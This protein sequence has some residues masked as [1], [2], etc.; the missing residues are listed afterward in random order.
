MTPSVLGHPG[1][2]TDGGAEFGLPYLS[3]AVVVVLVST[4][5]LV[6]V[7]QGQAPLT[8]WL[9]E[10]LAWIVFATILV[11]ELTLGRLDM[12]RDG[13]SGL[14]ELHG[15]LAWAILSVAIALGWYLSGAT[16]G[17]LKNILPGV[18]IFHILL[19][20]IRTRRQA[21][22]VVQLYI[23][24]LA[25]NAI[26]G[27]LQYL[28]DAFYLVAP[29]DDNAWKA[30]YEGNFVLTTANGLQTTPNNLASILL[31]GIVIIGSYIY[32]RPSINW[33]GFIRVALFVILM[34]GLYVSQS[35][36]GIVWCAVGL[37]VVWIPV[38]RHLLLLSIIIPI[39]VSLSITAYGLLWSDAGGL[40][41]STTIVRVV[42][43]LTAWEIISQYNQVA[44]FG[45]GID[46]MRYW[47]N[48]VGAWNFPNAHNTWVNQIILFGWPGLA[49]YIAMWCRVL[50]ALASGCVVAR[51]EEE[52]MLRGILGALVG[53]AGMYVFEPREDGVSHVAQLFILFGLAIA[54]TRAMGY[55]RSAPRL[56]MAR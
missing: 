49:L 48:A 41:T 2:R 3:L 13:W 40:D 45:N 33:K 12:L 44:F 8:I 10:I 56:G 36:G 19:R 38:R 32:Y 15:Y 24:G 14:P 39:V 22:V 27:I 26:F 37:M 6:V 18:L 54:V 28:T 7:A 47:T 30:D 4:I 35:K 5:D 53:L 55:G 21:E 51:G 34:S 1:Q 31:P 11:N 50:R 52:P 16:V 23:V 17:K 42:L 29:L 46:L 20:S 9:L 25:A 43:W